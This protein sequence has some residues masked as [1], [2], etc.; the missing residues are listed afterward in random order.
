MAGRRAAASA[1]D[2][3]LN[4]IALLRKTTYAVSMSTLVVSS[5][6]QIVLPASTRRRLG[7]GA[8]SKLQVFEEGDD[9]RLR[10]VR[11]VPR[12]AVADLAG[13]VKLKA[14]GV[15]RRLDDFDPA[16]LTAARRRRP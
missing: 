8:G 2:P 5:K 1:E 13:M 15:P 4:S 16:S 11:S 12:V 14:R 10:V 9:V 3:R 7:L 6:G